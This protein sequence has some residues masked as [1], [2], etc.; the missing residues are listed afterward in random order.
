VRCV[1]SGPSSVIKLALLAGNGVERMPDGTD[2]GDGDTQKFERSRKGIPD[3]H[4][5]TG[6]PVA[7]AAAPARPNVPPPLYT[8][9]HGLS[10]SL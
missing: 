4:A 6:T 9:A 3:D 7:G 5:A 8:L 10:H 1:W 2:R